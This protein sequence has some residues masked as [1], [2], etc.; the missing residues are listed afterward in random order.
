[1]FLVLT[2]PLALAAA[3][4]G[5]SPESGDLGVAAE[6]LLSPSTTSLDF[7]TVARGSSRTLTVTLTNTGT[8]N[9]DITSITSSSPPFTIGTVQPCVRPGN[10]VNVPI[11]FAPTTTGTQS[12]TVTINYT[13]GGVAQTPI[14][15][16]VTGV[17]R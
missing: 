14:V 4:C 9:D 1:M 3:G 17:G 11:T 6:A 16:H 13:E 8:V 2:A 5:A 10:R 15:V 7:G 12:G